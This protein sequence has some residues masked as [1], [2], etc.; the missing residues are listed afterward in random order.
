MAQIIEIENTWQGAKFCCPACG[1]AVFTED[2][3]PTDTPCEHVLFSWINE[4]GDYYNPCSDIV[5][6][7]QKSEEED[8]FMPSPYDEEFQDSLP[9]TAVLFALSEH[10]IACGPVCTTIIHA[11]TFPSDESI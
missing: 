10:G 11:I 1:K 4:V 6:L 9:E 2:G 8:E 7:L 3:V 5:K